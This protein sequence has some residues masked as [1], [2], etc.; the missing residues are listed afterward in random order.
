MSGVDLI[1]ELERRE[2]EAPRQLS[3]PLTGNELAKVCLYVY[4]GRCP[5]AGA[6]CCE[7]NVEDGD[8]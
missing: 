6:R 1:V 5:S 4:G 8:L 7:T 2:H 3:R